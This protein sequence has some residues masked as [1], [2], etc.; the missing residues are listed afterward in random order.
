MRLPAA[1]QWDPPGIQSAHVS[2]TAQV[3]AVFGR[4][5]AI[6]PRF[7]RDGGERLPLPVG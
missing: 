1:A 6:A 7:R 5:N 2:A 3:E 4:V